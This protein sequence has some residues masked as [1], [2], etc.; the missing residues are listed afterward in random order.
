MHVPISIE[1]LKGRLVDC[2]HV[3]KLI[4]NYPH[5]TITIDALRVN[6]HWVSLTSMNQSVRFKQIHANAMPVA[7]QKGHISIFGDFP[8]LNASIETKLL[9]DNI[10]ASNITLQTQ[11]TFPWQWH[12]TGT[13]SPAESNAPLNTK[14][15]LSADIQD[16]Q[17]GSMILKTTKSSYLF[18]KDSPLPKLSFDE[19]II[20]GTL[21]EQ[22]LTIDGTMALNKDQKISLA[23]QLPHFNLENGL[24]DSQKLNATLNFTAT[25]FD[26]LTNY[27]PFL[28]NPQ[29]KLSVTLNARGTVAKHQVTT[30]LQ[31]KNARAALPNLGLNI[32]TIDLEAKAI[33]DR[34]QANGL[35]IAEGKTLTLKGDGRLFPELNAN[36]SFSSTDFP[37]IHTNEYQVDIAPEMKL[38]YAKSILDISGRVLVQK[39]LIKL[40]SF[41]NTIELPS[42]VVLSTQEAPS[43][44][45]TP[46]AT[47]MDVQVDMGSNVELFARGLHAL[48]EGGIHLT[49]V[50]QGSINAEGELNVD[51]GE[52]KAYGQTLSI[53]QGEL[54]FTGG[55]IDNPGLNLRASKTIHTSPVSNTNTNFN[56]LFNLNNFNTQAD[57][58][59]ENLTVG[60]EVTG[61]LN[62]PEVSLFSNPAVLSQADTLSMLVL[63]RPANQANKAG[64]QLLLAAISS[65]NSGKGVQGMRLFEQVKQNLG[66]DFDMQ[67]TSSYNQLTNTFN[68]SSSFV[69]TKSLSNRIRLS[70]NVGLSQA[71][72]NVLTLKYLLN[73]F[74]S[75]QVSSSTNSSGVDL[76]YT[77]TKKKLKE[78]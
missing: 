44:T 38:F 17:H 76:F 34:W 73:K 5:N 50:P 25:S 53:K 60:V 48:L 47:K 45:S 58:L 7:L 31:L 55:S 40:H 1:G 27:L 13:L 4:I 10:Q 33:E 59:P 75:I 11:G 20:K 32:T 43:T 54:L 42:E 28:S 72:P 61:R 29:G 22:A 52:Y 24:T 3:D 67:T 15:S 71:D 26:F 69:V 8:K 30:L 62:A 74:F 56:Q 66:L 19:G 35:L 63:G 41:S 57:S 65:M 70:Y 6:S 14:I 36:I 51:K 9:S 64:G 46:I 18:K 21:K 2:W 77:S 16:S 37:V 39:A 23:I 78:S 49:Q 68:E 12:L